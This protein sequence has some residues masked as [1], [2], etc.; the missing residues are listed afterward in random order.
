MA[1]TFLVLLTLRSKFEIFHNV[2]WGF[3]L[4]ISI[5]VSS[6]EKKHEVNY[7]L[8]W[9]LFLQSVSTLI[10]KFRSFLKYK[11]SLPRYNAIKSLTNTKFSYFSTIVVNYYNV[12][13][14]QERRVYFSFN[15]WNL[16]P[17]KC[18]SLYFF[19]ISIKAC[20]IYMYCLYWTFEVGNLFENP[21]IHFWQV[22]IKV[23]DTS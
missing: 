21:I 20:Q 16:M 23:W 1:Q 3:L 2:H 12:A 19:G 5:L 22:V 4:K 13:M 8:V 10:V 7:G 14:L 6:R 18:T 9:T 17:N 11:E 15:P